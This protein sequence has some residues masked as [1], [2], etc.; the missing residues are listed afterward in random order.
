M[1]IRPEHRAF[2]TSPEWAAI[3]TRILARAGDKCEW[4]DKPNRQKMLVARGGYWCLL[5]SS[6]WRDCQGV[7]IIRPPHH[8]SY[9][10]IRCVLT[11]A[12]LDHNPAN[13]DDANLAALCQ[14]CH[15]VHDT[16]QHYAN[17][18]RTRAEQCGQ[19]WIL[20]ELEARV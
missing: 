20:P 5:E 9:R 11:I 16:H 10:A 4:C 2:Y 12:H 1:P 13:N 19:T 8:E 14:R 17:A 7:V 3:R 18:R 6:T 15:L